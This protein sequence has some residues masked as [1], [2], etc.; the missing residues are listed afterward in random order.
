MK[1]KEIFFRFC[2]VFVIEF[3]F[4]CVGLICPKFSK[5][6]TLNFPFFY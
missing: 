4:G 6:L 1:E 3:G 2:G 5:S